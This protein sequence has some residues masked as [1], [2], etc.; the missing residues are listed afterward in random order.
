MPKPHLS[1]TDAKGQTVLILGGTSVVGFE[2]A[3][4]IARDIEPALIVIV[5]LP[6]YQVRDALHALRKEF[7]RVTFDGAWS[8]MFAS[9]T[10]YKWLENILVKF[11]PLIIVDASTSTSVI[12]KEAWRSAT[13]KAQKERFSN[14]QTPVMEKVDEQDL[15]NDQL[16]NEGLSQ[17][18]DQV[19]LFHETMRRVGTWMYLK[20]SE[21]GQEMSYQ[22]LFPL[23]K[24]NPPPQQ[25]FAAAFTF[26][27]TGLL[28]L[29]SRTFDLPIIKEIKA[30]AIIGYR[31][32]DYSPVKWDN[33]K[34]ELF[35]AKKVKIPK[36][37]SF[38]PDVGY[39]RLGDL[40]MVG[41]ETSRYGV[42][43]RGEFE[44]IASLLQLEFVTP[45]EIAKAVVQEI[46]GKN[47]G[48]DVIAAINTAVVKPS[49]HAAMLRTKI[50]ESMRQLESKNRSVSVSIGQFGMFLLVNLV[51]PKCQNCCTKHIY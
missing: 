46:S 29:M 19:R 48:H 33:G 11:K 24:K 13:D 37:W 21:F 51:H 30:P 2:I 16:A 39:A 34:G 6:Q 22:T 5:S 20:I 47:T 49:Q 23:G 14:Q 45:T 38:R 41:V 7:P 42:L 12:G 44:A 9:Q 31:S 43:A 40:K 26:A 3:R 50:V 18:I 1:K 36:N 4:Q 25:M 28:F 27:H 10:R 15:S 35:H 8:D 17:L 32:I